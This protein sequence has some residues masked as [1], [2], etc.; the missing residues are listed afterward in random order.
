[1][2]EIS[3]EAMVWIISDPVKVNVAQACSPGSSRYFP[4]PGVCLAESLLET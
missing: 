2:E 1:M 4:H 3:K